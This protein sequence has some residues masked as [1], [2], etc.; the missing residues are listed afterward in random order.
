MRRRAVHTRAPAPTSRTSSIARRAA[1]GSA[2]AGLW[3]SDQLKLIVPDVEPPPGHRDLEPAPRANV[4]AHLLWRHP[5]RAD[6]PPAREPPTQ[7]LLRH[8]RAGDRRRAHAEHR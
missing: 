6:Q 8:A 2:A 4:A 1:A 7:L 5:H 3:L